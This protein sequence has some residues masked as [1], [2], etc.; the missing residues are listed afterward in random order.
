MKI[1]KKGITHG[2]KFHADDVFATA[3]LKKLYP[4][5]TVTRVISVPDSIPD[6]TVVYDIGRGRFDHHQIDTPQ[7]ENGIRYAAFGLLWKE[8]GALAC[9]SEN[10]QQKLDSSFVQKLD[11][12]D[13]NGTHDSVSMVISSYNPSWD[14]DESGDNAFDKA[15]SMAADILHNLINYELG[16]E[17]AKE[18]VNLAYNKMHNKTVIL[19]RFAPFKSVLAETDAVFVIYPSNRGGYNIQCIPVSAENN[20]SKLPF[21]ESWCGKEGEDLQSESGYKSIRFVHK[22]GFIASANEFEEA[23]KIAADLVQSM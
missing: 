13:N 4:D 1:Y 16:S 18:E 20:E 5:F 9:G 21:P 6:D 22:S 7:R 17:R 3:L 10:I 8:Y 15:V 12:S 11:D 19:E 14:S 23:V 2:G